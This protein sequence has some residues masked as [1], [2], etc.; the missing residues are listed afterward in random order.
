MFSCYRPVAIDVPIPEGQRSLAPHE[1]RRLLRLAH[2]DQVAGLR[3]VRALLHGDRRPAVLERHAPAL[4]L[5]GRLSRRSRSRA[6]RGGQGQ[7]DDHRA[8]C[9]PAGAAGVHAARSAPTRAS[10]ATDIIYGTIRIIEEDDETV[11]AWARQRWACIV[12]NLHVEHTPEGIATAGGALPPPDRSRDRARRQLLPDYHRWATAEQARLPSA[13]A[14]VPRREAP[15]RSQR[16]V[17]ERLVHASR[18]AV[19][20]RQCEPV[21]RRTRASRSH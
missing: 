15:D 11:L 21:N 10:T 19:S 8:L 16:C 18:R 17:H 1:W 14:R 9:A 20:Q 6:R 12:F 5:S 3:R 7:R 4:G 13:A 2:T